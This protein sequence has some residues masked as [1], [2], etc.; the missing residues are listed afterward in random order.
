MA[1]VRLGFYVYV[2]KFSRDLFGP[3]ICFAFLARRNFFI[4]S[5]FLCRHNMLTL[6]S[7]KRLIFK[8]LLFISDYCIKSTFFCGLKLII[9]NKT[10]CIFPVPITSK[11]WQFATLASFRHV[12]LPMRHFAKKASLRQSVTL[13]K[14]NTSSKKVN[15]WKTS[16]HQKSVTLEKRARHYDA[17]LANWRISG[18]LTLFL[19]KWSLWRSDLSKWRYYGA[20][21]GYPYFEVLRFRSDPFWI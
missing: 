12:T 16:L 1:W 10:S 5:E 6:S 18:A 8:N 4:S 20:C 21:Q 19:A 2:I 15:S 7:K 17:F 11:E 3:K 14:N 13:S 9:K